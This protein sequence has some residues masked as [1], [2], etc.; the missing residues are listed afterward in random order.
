MEQRRRPDLQ[1]SH[2][3]LWEEPWICLEQGWRIS[4]GGKVRTTDRQKSVRKARQKAQAY[5]VPPD[6]DR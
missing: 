1:P 4:Q 3:G 6:R 5:E 2:S